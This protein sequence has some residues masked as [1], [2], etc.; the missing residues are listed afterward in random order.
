[1]SVPLPRR[2]RLASPGVDLD[3]AQLLELVNSH[4]LGGRPLRVNPAEDRQAPT[5]IP[6]FAPYGFGPSP[7][8]R[9]GKPK[10]SRRNLR[11]RKRSL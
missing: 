7:G 8:K 10:G 5:G 9:M 11:A 3:L 1:M 4:E 2:R 6:S